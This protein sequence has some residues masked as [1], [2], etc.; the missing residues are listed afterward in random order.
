MTVA[1]PTVRRA[2]VV[3]ALLAALLPLTACTAD[4]PAPTPTSTTDKGSPPAPEIP[5]AWPLT[6]VESD[7]VAARPALA[8]KVENAPQARPQTGLEDADMVWEEVV[9]G[10]ITRFVAVYHS[11]LPEA[12]E[13]VRSVRPMD[14][15]VVA[16]L[17]GILAYTGGQPPFV[18]AVRDAGVQSVMMDAGDAGFTRDPQRSAPHDVIGD[19]AAFLDLADGDRTVPPPAQLEYADAA[20]EGTASSDGTKATTLDV[21]LSPAQRTVWDWSAGTDDGGWQRSDGS[22][23]SV[24][25]DGDRLTA[26]NVLVLSTKVVDTRYKD[27]AGAPVPE[28]KLVGSGEGL[29]ASGGRTVTLRWSKE[30]VD[31]PVELTRDGEPVELDPGSTWIELVPRDGGSWSVS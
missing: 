7:D 26:T 2:P 24:S 12:V 31:A 17:G 6:G 11:R 25:A 8:V 19:P 22:T 3:A 16:P 14:P 9:E 15:A 29:L 5:P 10:G 4:D 27:P 23:P 18:Q 13:P 28:T 21:V 20:G 1:P 30:S